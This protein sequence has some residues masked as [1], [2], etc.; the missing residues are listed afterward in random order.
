[1]LKLCKFK[2]TYNTSD[3]NLSQ[4][5]YSLSLVNSIKYYRGVGYFTSGW[6]KE[7]AY[8]LARFIKDN[9]QIKFITSPNLDKVD[10]DALSGQ[11][12]LEQINHS[13]FVD[14]ELLEKQLEEN[15]RNLLGWLIHDGYLEFKFAVPTLGLSGGE[16]HDKFGIFIDENNDYIAFNG[17][18]NDSIKAY[19]NYE[20]IS[21]FKSWGDETSQALANETLKRFER[22][23]N[24]EDKNLKIY[25]LEELSK[26]KLIKFRNAERP[27][28]SNFD[29][30]KSKMSNNVAHIPTIPDF[31]KLREYQEQAYLNWKT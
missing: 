22:I 17:S 28:K 1:M 27:Y 8:G 9:N 4:D 14:I 3:D 10:F 25:S 5:F 24:G 30:E 26:D 21:V 23:W 13:I 6:I 16:F 11:F 29:V 2:I 18:Q 12:N 19:K 7:N 15:T 20:S 31:L